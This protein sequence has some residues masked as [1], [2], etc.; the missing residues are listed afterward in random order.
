MVSC[1][2]IMGHILKDLKQ[3]Q[4]GPDESR[5]LRGGSFDYYESK[6]RSS[7]RNFRF[8]PTFG[9]PDCGFRLARGDL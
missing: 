5:V 6:A 9:D 2:I 4:N 8:T 1:S 3:T 7:S